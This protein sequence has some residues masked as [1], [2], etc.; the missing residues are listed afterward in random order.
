MPISMN[1]LIY[2]ILRITSHKAEVIDRM[3]REP[4]AYG[5]ALGGLGYLYHD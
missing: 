5:L 2:G 3:S 4:K 1:F